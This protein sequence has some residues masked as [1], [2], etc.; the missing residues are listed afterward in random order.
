MRRRVRPFEAVLT[1]IIA[2][3]CGFVIL[4]VVT[5]FAIAIATLK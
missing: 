5:F 1:S 2:L 4:G 3:S